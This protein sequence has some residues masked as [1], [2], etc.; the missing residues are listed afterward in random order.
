MYDQNYFAN[1]NISSITGSK[2]WKTV[3][4]LFSNKIS[5]KEPINSVVNDAMQG[6]HAT[7]YNL[8]HRLT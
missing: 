8:S 7:L 2:F 5:H 6:E 4:P 1:V 3:K